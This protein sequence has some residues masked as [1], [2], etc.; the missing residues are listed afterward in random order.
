MT[1]S[2]HNDPKST[3]YLKVDVEECSCLGQL[4][5]PKICARHWPALLWGRLLAVGTDPRI[6]HNDAWQQLEHP[7]LFLSLADPNALTTSFN[8]QKMVG[9][10]IRSGALSKCTLTHICTSSLAVLSTRYLQLESLSPGIAPK[11]TAAS[12]LKL[13]IKVS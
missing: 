9:P 8:S 6:E 1:K 10:A 5:L 4:M 12:L 7:L 11:I 2:T 3:R 13:R